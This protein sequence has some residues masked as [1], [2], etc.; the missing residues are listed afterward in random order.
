MAAATFKDWLGER[1]GEGPGRVSRRELARRLAAAPD[2]ATDA[3]S[4]RRSI[5]RFLDGAVNPTNA[6]RKSIGAVLGDDS[7]PMVEDEDEEDMAATLQALVREQAA[8]GRRIR[9]VAR[10]AR[11]E[12]VA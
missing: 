8:I 11:Q 6:T 2:G 4:H 7:Y 10:A 3:E 5:R 9:K 1:V 12:R